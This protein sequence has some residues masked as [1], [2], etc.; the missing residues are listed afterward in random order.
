MT[1]FE[2]LLAFLFL[3][4]VGLGLALR[5]LRS[6][7]EEAGGNPRPIASQP[8]DEFYRPMAR[9]FTPRDIEFLRKQRGYSSTMDRRLRL[10]RQKVLRLY[11]GQIREDF[12]ALLG[13][14]R[15]LARSTRNWELSS[16]AQRQMVVFY[17]V[18]FA[19]QIR[20]LLGSFVY[21]RVDT[22][23][24]VSSLRS[25]QEGVRSVVETREGALE[26][27]RG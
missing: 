17:G 5:R 19:L 25:L 1:T 12:S 26:A 2:I 6:N 4:A 7:G 3:V 13:H 16:L 10:Q 22:R 27:A 20:C 18:Y 15:R 23:E 14:C 24:L 9:L 8:V 21:I 11:L